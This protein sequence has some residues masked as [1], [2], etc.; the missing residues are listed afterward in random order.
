[1]TD[2][3]SAQSQSRLNSPQMQQTDYYAVLGVSSAASVQDIR[4]AYRELSK[5]Y[6]PDT[7][8]LPPEPARQKFQE[9]TQAYA[10]LSDAAKRLKYDRQRAYLNQQLQSD[11]KTQTAPH[12][13]TPSTQ[14]KSVDTTILNSQSAY[15]PAEERSLSPGELFALFILGLTFAGCIV[16]AITLGLTRGELVIDAPH[17]DLS[18]DMTTQPIEPME[19]KIKVTIQSEPEI[20]RSS[21]NL[22]LQTS[23]V[24]SL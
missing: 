21:V 22:E 7:T 20:L 5:C 9:I 1:M 3:R 19:P 10:I 11:R 18:T 17:F 13:S 15:L 24:D 4:Q 12:A 2:N 8:L 6:H 14:S 16:L 23:L